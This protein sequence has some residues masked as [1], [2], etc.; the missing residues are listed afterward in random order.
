MC[1][2]AESFSWYKDE[3]VGQLCF[4]FH[5]IKNLSVINIQTMFLQEKEQKYQLR[6][7]GCKI[8]DLEAGW[9]ARKAAFALFNPD[10][11]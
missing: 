9:L 3:E 2:L 8:R 5:D 1:F 7:E 6:L 11:K 4:V 10:Q